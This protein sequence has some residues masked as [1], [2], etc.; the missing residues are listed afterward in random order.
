[1]FTEYSTN[2][3]CTC[4]VQ[5]MGSPKSPKYCLSLSALFYCLFSKEMV[6]NHTKPRLDRIKSKSAFPA[7][8]KNILYFRRGLDYCCKTSLTRI[9]L[10]LNFLE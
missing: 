7:C 5:R 8:I 4:A 3:R 1:M 9:T 10:K 2:M 6:V